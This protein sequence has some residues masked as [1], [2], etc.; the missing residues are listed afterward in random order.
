MQDRDDAERAKQVEQALTHYPIGDR[1]GVEHIPMGLIHGTYRVE[2]ATGM[3]IVQRL[4]PDL[5]SDSNLRDYQAVTAH[6]ADQSFPAPRLILTGEGNP[7]AD[8]R[9]DRYRLTTFL[10][11]ES[12]DCVKNTRMVKEAALMLGSF[13]TAMADFRYEFQAGRPLHDSPK[14]LEFLQ[15]ALRQFRNH[16]MMGEVGPLAEKVST[17]LPRHFLPTPWASRVVHGDPKISNVLFDPATGRAVGLIDLD[18][19]ARHT[20]LVDI[21]DAV[22]SWCREG[23][24][25]QATPFL[26]DRFRAFCEGYRQS[27]APLSGAE[28]PLIA[29]SCRLITLELASRFLR[30]AL[31]DRYF[32][33][34]AARFASRPAHNLARAKGC[35]FLYESMAGQREEMEKVVG[36]V[37]G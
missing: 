7:S 24:E 17:D 13:H 18:S 8:V 36:E 14:H 3:Y 26:A 16:P 21:G 2:S 1:V 30:D 10:K 5:S 35:L 37:W 19:C 20:V 29:P 34:D 4:H 31:E 33:W 11:G 25:D 27:D 12:Y 23:P 32:G 22:R 9:G 15:S 6:L 28:R